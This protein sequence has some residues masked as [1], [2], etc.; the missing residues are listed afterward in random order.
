MPPDLFITRGRVIDPSTRTDR[1]ADVVLRDGLVA[2]VGPG[3]A[4]PA[5]ARTIDARCHWVVPGLIDVH[6]HLREPGQEYKED[7]V[8][9]TAAAAAGGF[10]AVCAM[11]NTNPV[12]DTR[13]ITELIRERARAAGRVRVYP[14]GA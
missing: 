12:N 7:I 13:A 9:G 6:A 14:I 11:P 8:T 4:A 5:G 3:L 2:E 10:T 1:E